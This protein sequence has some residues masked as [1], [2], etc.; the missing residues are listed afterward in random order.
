MS[1]LAGRIKVTFNN[2]SF[3]KEFDLK[4]PSRASPATAGPLPQSVCP[5]SF[6]ATQSSPLRFF[7]SPIVLFGEERDSYTVI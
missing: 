6:H 1:R 4:S 3:Q 2:T 5:S 7:E